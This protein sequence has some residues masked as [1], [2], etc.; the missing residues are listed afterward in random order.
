MHRFEEC[1]EAYYALN[2]PVN[3]KNNGGADNKN[4]FKK[5]LS[6]EL[7]CGLSEASCLSLPCL[8]S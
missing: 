6:P 1:R 8:F 4:I 3:N 2:D 7:C 5:Y